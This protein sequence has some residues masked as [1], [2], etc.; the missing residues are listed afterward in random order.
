ME[1]VPDKDKPLEQEEGQTVLLLNITKL[2]LSAQLWM[3]QQ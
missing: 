1:E 2:Q 3:T